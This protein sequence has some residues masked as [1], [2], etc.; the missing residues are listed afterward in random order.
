MADRRRNNTARMDGYRHQ[1]RMQSTYIEGNTAR[2]LDVY[3]EP[4]SG[5]DYKEQRVREVRLIRNRARA[6][7]MNLGFVIFLAAASVVFTLICGQY[8]QVRAEVST[9]ASRVESLEGQLRDLRTANDYR[10]NALESMTDI[11]HVYDVAVNQLGMV[12]PS[13]DQLVT[14]ESTPSEY[15]IQ[16]GS[17]E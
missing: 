13:Q 17:L 4:L 10:Q 15:V 6:R 16:S 9:A 3:S 1:S 5:I 2:K 11:N 8:L 14:Y 12:Y 7:Q